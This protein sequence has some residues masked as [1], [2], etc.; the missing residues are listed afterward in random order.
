MAITQCFSSRL[1]GLRNY[2]KALKKAL[3]DENRAQDTDQPDT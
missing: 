2:R 1:D 3:A